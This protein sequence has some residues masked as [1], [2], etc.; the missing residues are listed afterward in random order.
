MMV[1]RERT[2]CGTPPEA[3]RHKIHWS[4]DRGLLSGEKHSATSES[5]VAKMTKYRKVQSVCFLNTVH[6][7]AIQTFLIKYVCVLVLNKHKMV[8][9]FSA[10]VNV[11]VSELCP[12]LM[13]RGFRKW[14]SISWQTQTEYIFQLKNKWVMIRKKNS[15]DSLNSLSNLRDTK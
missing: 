12:T 13:S 1:V 2:R 15:F 5:A 9:W 3:Y 7:W 8:M 11:I 10:M 14:F 4:T 6:L